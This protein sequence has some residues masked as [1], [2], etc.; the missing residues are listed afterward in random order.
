MR[1]AGI[2]LMMAAAAM[3][4]S[5][6][7]FDVASIKLSGPQSVRGS[8]GGPGTSEP[9]R[10]S[11]H[12]ATLRDLVL[13]AFNKHDYDSS[14]K[15]ALDEHRF[16]LD[17]SMPAGT[18]KA[19]FHEML[20]ALLEERFHLKTHVES[21]EIAAFE[22]TIAKG[23]FKLKEGVAK[24][25]ADESAG[26]FPVVPEGR[27]GI[28]TT[29]RSMGQYSLA[30]MRARQQTIGSLA[31]FLRMPGEGPIVEKTGLTGK[32]DFTFE[33]AMELAGRHADEP[34]EAPD[35]FSALEKQ[36]GLHLTPKKLPY[37]VLVVDA[38]DP[39]PSA[40]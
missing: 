7:A 39:M 5:G 20:K 32:Y 17:V 35:F 15:V 28:S 31:E 29:F 21:R 40:N 9:E 34:P 19:Q 4:Q 8:R 10:Y 33:Y 16:D 38:A 6:P 2:A 18:T 23:G 12:L 13:T 24:Q 25:G 37:D 36:L 27:P 14:S 30:R 26:G 22:L 3:A 11:F 1:A